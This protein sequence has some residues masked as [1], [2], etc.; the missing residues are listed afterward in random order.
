MEDEDPVPVYERVEVV[1]HR[2]ESV[3]LESAEG[4]A[5]FRGEGVGEALRYTLDP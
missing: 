2:G 1:Y 5:G 4:D 3:M